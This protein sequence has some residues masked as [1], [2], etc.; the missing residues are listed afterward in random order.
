M[1]QREATPD[2]VRSMNPDAVICS[3]GIGSQHTTNSGNHRKKCD[4]SRRKPTIV[5]KTG[6]SIGQNVVVLGG[7]LVGCET[8]LFLAT[9][10]GKTVTIIEMSDKVAAEEM[11]LTRDALLDR[12]NERTTVITSAVCTAVLEDGLEYAMPDGSKK[13]IPCDTV[14]LSAG[15]SLR[16]DFAETFRDCAP[17]F[18]SIGDCKLASNV[19]NATRTGFDAAV[20]I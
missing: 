11:Y 16:Q 12:L 19:R 18:V 15:M 4:H 8:G 2:Q 17:W 7:G 13:F 9:V 14:V 6:D 20:R 10:A 3:C 5:V 1:L